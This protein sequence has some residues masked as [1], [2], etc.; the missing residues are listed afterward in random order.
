VGTLSH[1]LHALTLE[2]RAHL[3]DGMDRV[4]DPTQLA[5]LR[6]FRL[7]GI[8]ADLIKRNKFNSVWTFK[9]LDGNQLLEVRGI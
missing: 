8:S 1:V 2:L 6:H 4:W 7:I 3:T 9:D 5:Q